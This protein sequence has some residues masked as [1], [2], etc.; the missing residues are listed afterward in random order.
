[1]NRER[2]IHAVLTFINFFIV[3]VSHE[4]HNQKD[5]SLIFLTFSK[6]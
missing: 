5:F 1:M 3:K 4:T 6:D 2:T